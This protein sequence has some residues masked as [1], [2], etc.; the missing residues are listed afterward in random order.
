MGARAEIDAGHAPGVST[1]ENAWMK[2]LE[3]EVRELRRTNEILKRAAY[4]FGVELHR[5]HKW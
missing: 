2:E 5:Q 4:F 1:A 3:Q